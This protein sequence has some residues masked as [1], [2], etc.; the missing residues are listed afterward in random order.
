MIANLSGNTFLD[1]AVAGT[2]VVNCS[3]EDQAGEFF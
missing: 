1:R 2:A 3:S